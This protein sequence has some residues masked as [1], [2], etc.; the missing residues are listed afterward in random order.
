MDE[1]L[2]ARAHQ[3]SGDRRREARRRGLRR[4]ARRGPCRGHPHTDGGRAWL[5]AT[6]VLTGV[7]GGWGR[8]VLD[9]FLAEGWNVVAT[10]REEQRP[11][12]L[13]QPVAAV[14]ADLSDPDAAIAVV[15]A[16]V[17][18]F[19]GVDAL[20]HIAGGFA[21][22]GTI[23]EQPVDVWRSQMAINLDTAYFMTRAAL[24]PMRGAGRGSIVYIGTSAMLTP[25][26]G[27]S[28]YIVSKVALGGLMRCVDVEFR[29]AGIRANAHRRQDRRHAPKPGREPRRRPLAL[30]DGRGAGRGGGVALHRR[31][32]APLG[33]AD[34]GVWPRL[35]P[36]PSRRP[37]R[38]ST[39]RR[40]RRAPERRSGA[41]TSAGSTSAP[42]PRSRSSTAASPRWSRRTTSG[43]RT[44]ASRWWTAAARS[45]SRA[46]S[47]ATR[48]RRSAATGPASSTCAPRAPTT[49]ASTRR[50]GGSARPSR[51]PAASGR[52]AWPRPSAGTWGWMAANGTTTAEGKSGYGLDRETELASAHGRGRPAPDRDR[53]DVPRR[54]LGAAR[55]RLRGRVPGLR[56]RRGAAGGR[57]G[58]PST[59]TSSSSAARSRPSRPTGTCAPR[60]ATAWSPR[61]HGDQFTESGAVPLAIELGARSVDHLEATGPDGVARSRRATSRRCS[62]PL[63]RSIL[64][65]PAPPARALVDAG[66]IVA[67]AT[68]FNPGSA[69]C[70]SLPLVMTLACTALGMAPAEALAACTVNAAWVLGRADRAGRLAPGYDA[71]IV[72]LDAPDWRLRRLPP[73]GPR[74]RR[75][76]RPRRED[77][78]WLV[79]GVD[80]VS[81]PWPGSNL[82][83]MHDTSAHSRDGPGSDPSPGLAR[84]RAGL[85]R[86]RDAAP[87]AS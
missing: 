67:L 60:S 7:T 55:V 13:P 8:A 6:A 28:G 10:H 50:A 16:A 19:G 44:A 12:D 9:R 35:S 21:A 45:R 58:G 11:D 17:E 85:V 36:A 34:P 43:A 62:C 87:V 65:P 33:R 51:R 1:R 41:P 3:R 15:D 26:S 53:A 14:R 63:R 73:G 66:A 78:G 80:Q 47:T 38:P 46:S 42:R 18:R 5:T 48:T 56:D 23:D 2:D 39:R 75:R 57:A 32:G 25:F 31:V 22:A 54:A 27:A 77:R 59:P 24:T 71:D 79:A 29:T 52:T 84:T 82:T 68:D 70:D 61:L 83:Q 69:F 30:D 40:R 81:P 86:G 4:G 76:L 20:A 64:A 37:R 74:H 49:S 72:L